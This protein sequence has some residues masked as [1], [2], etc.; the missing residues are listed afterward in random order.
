MNVPAYQPRDRRPIKSRQTRW[1]EAIAKSLATRG[2]SPNGISI[3][4]LL[5]AL[6][7]GMCFALTDGSSELVARGLWLAG[8]AFCQL[9]LLCNLFDGMVAIEREIAS[10]QGEIYN[11]VP[12]R[13]ADAAI[14][15]GLGH[16]VG[17]DLSLGYGAA[18]V[19]L[20]VAYVRVAMKSIGAPSDFGGP[21][22]KQHRMAVVTVL[23]CYL[24]ISPI[25][26]RFAW[27]E[28]RVVLVTIIVGGAITAWLRLRK[29]FRYFENSIP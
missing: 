18:L 24:S 7:A 13:L 26:W 22:A 17:S 21:M 12:D 6:C 20:F 2:V 5:F 9:R 16:A 11:E 19:A 3:A 15:I 1:A 4:G 27:S 25:A 23:A 10:P 8:A 29:A 14:F 28:V